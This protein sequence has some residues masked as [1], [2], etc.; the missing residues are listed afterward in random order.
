MEHLFTPQKC[1]IE[2]TRGD[3]TRER[4]RERVRVTW[5]P[6]GGNVTQTLKFKGRRNGFQ[7]CHS[8]AFPSDK[9]QNSRP[10][11]AIPQDGEQRRNSSPRSSPDLEVYLGYETGVS[12]PIGLDGWY[13]IKDNY[14]FATQKIGSIYDKVVNISGCPPRIDN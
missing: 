1:W 5:G 11:M 13:K 14:L 8:L 4:E 7:L 2:S 9:A 3:E 12:T 6:L 10:G